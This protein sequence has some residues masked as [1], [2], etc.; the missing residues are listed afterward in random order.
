MDKCIRN[1]SL[2]VTLHL[3]CTKSWTENFHPG[4]FAVSELLTCDVTDDITHI[5]RR[6]VS[7]ATSSNQQIKL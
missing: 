6:V 2:T 1:L 5:I 3:K 4:K 7:E